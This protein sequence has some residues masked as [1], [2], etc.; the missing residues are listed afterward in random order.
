MRPLLSI[1]IATKDREQY[2]I[3]TIQSILS[4][5][6]DRIQIAVADNSGTTAVKEFVD[7]IA[8][9]NNP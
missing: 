5:D 1:A 3:K 4:F 7:I 2:C 6:D 9:P 8:S